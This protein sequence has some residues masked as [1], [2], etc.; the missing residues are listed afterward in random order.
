LAR[1]AGLEPATYGF[2]VR[3]SIQLSYGR[4]NAKHNASDTSRARHRDGIAAHLTVG[5]TRIGSRP[6]RRLL[7][8]GAEEALMPDNLQLDDARDPLAEDDEV[9]DAAEDDEELEDEDEDE[10][11]DLEDDSAR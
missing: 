3:R 10:E 4:T 5:A 7:R 6:A 2:E 1:P 9:I 8:A 11:E